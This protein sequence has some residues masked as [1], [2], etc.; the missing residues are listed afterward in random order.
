[1]GSEMCI[2]DRL[3]LPQDAFVTDLAIIMILAGIVTL[4]FF[5]IKQPLIIGYL[6]AGMLIGPLSPLWAPFLSESAGNET[7][8][9]AGLLSDIAALNVFAEIGVILLL[10]VIGIEFPFA[11]IR[12]IGKVAIGVGTLGLFLTLIVVFYVCTMMGLGFMDSLF[13]GAALSISS[14]A[15][16]VKVLEETG[17]IKKESSWLL[18]SSPS[19]CLLYTSDAADE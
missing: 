17:K 9:A 6:F 12:S 8:G 5:K 4:A 18:C 2:R 15:I 16:I 7:N 19:T 1:M 13:L 3:Q 11:K 10:F 14:T